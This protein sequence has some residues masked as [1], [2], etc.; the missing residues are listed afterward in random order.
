VIFFSSYTTLVI[1]NCQSPAVLSLKN[2]LHNFGNYFQLS[3][4]DGGQSGRFSNSDQSRHLA[5]ALLLKGWK[6]DEVIKEDNIRWIFDELGCHFHSA[7]GSREKH[8]MWVLLLF[9]QF[10][11]EV[12]FVAV[13]ATG[14]F[15]SLSPSNPRARS[16]ATPHEAIFM[17]PLMD[18]CTL[19]SKSSQTETKKTDTGCF[20]KVHVLPDLGARFINVRS[21]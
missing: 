11:L 4:P 6:E 14:L 13:V 8:A 9:Y 2:A 15:V 3:A 1:E 16:T 7:L 19:W 18:W 5:S 20:F 12:T 17:F 10:P 21:L